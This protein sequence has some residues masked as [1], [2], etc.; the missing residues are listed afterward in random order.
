M[1]DSPIKDH[2]NVRLVVGDVMDGQAL[3][4]AGRD[5]QIIIHL[6]AIAGVD[7]VMKHPVQTMKVAMIGTQNAL[8]LAQSL[9]GLECF[10]GFFDVGG[11]RF[12]RI[13]GG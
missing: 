11:L 8:D 6:A 7:T 12:S 4:K 1:K 2:P 9:S 13:P 5:V 3:K 10:I